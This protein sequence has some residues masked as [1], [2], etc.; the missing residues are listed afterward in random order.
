MQRVLSNWEFSASE[1]LGYKIVFSRYFLNVFVAETGSK[2][3]LSSLCAG[4]RLQQA[5]AGKWCLPQ[6]CWTCSTV[7][8][9]LAGSKVV[10]FLLTHL[11]FYVVGGLVQIVK[12]DS[13][14]RPQCLDR[15][16]C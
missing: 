8:G 7:E 1:A 10:T 14:E 4:S 15:Q 12:E 16:G 6:R 2:V 9:D 13:S 5:A 3:I 11:Q